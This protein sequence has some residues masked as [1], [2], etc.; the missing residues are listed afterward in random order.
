M[1]FHPVPESGDTIYI[2]MY[3]TTGSVEAVPEGFESGLMMD[4][5]R[6]L[7]KLGTPA[8]FSAQQAFDKELK[9]MIRLDGPFKGKLI[10]IITG[11]VGP[12]GGQTFGEYFS[13]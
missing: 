1:Q 3:T 9:R 12:S 5:E 2:E 11:A 6:F 7:Y 8:R 4:I 13:R 10:E